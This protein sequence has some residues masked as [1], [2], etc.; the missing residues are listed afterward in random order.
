MP[1]ARAIIT[2]SL[3]SMNRLSPGEVVDSD[4]AAMA[5]RQL[6][7]IADQAGA[8]R[9]ALFKQAFIS[10][11]V[12]GPS[13]ALAAGVFSSIGVGDEIEG[14]TADNYP[15]SPITMA[16]YNSIFFKLSPGRPMFYAY[17]GAATVFLYPAAIANTMVIQ[18]RVDLSQF[19]D[20]DTNYPMPSGYL[21]FFSTALAVALAPSLLGGTPPELKE[22]ATSAKWSIEGTNIRP[23]IIGGNPISADSRSVGRG[24]IL[25]GW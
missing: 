8:G 15:M 16:Q 22:M 25:G 11:V 18:S 1:T 24:S 13:I 7:A 20:L 19:A 3:E 6:N 14:L 17:D 9:D 5:L 21:K 4:L 10:G 12:T 23:A 2:L